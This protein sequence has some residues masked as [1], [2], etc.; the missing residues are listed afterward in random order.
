[1]VEWW[2]T[3]GISPDPHHTTA[4]VQHFHQHH[5]GPWMA[6]NS[7][8]AKRKHFIRSDGCT[9]QF[10]CGRHFRWLSQRTES[11]GIPIEH[12]HSESCHGKDAGDREGGRVKFLLEQREMQ[13]TYD[14]PTQIDTSQE[15]YEYCTGVD[16]GIN[17]GRGNM[18]P[19]TDYFSKKG[20][21]CYKRV[22]STLVLKTS[23][24]IWQSVNQSPIAQ[25]C[26]SS[27]T[28]VDLVSYMLEKCRVTGAM[29][30]WR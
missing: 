15:V 26:T 3:F 21:G 12:S 29:H 6:Q 28:L 14:T 16:P 19:K 24:T 5:L 18:Q 7:P 25:E 8:L 22:S 10:K 4:F 20:R 27:M 17:G 13:H 1:M 9:D 23:T 11:G 2:L 30:A